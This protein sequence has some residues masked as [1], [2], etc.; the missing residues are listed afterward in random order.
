MLRGQLGPSGYPALD[1]T[2][3]G[4]AIAFGSAAPLQYVV[5][6]VFSPLNQ[7]PRRG[8]NNSDQIANVNANNNDT[9]EKC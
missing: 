5:L 3:L 2:L 9:N 4:Y 8:N 1:P 6:L 7:Y